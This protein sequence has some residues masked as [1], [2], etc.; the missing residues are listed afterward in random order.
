MENLHRKITNKEFQE[1]TTE[2]AKLFRSKFGRKAHVHVVDVALLL[3]VTNF[4][5]SL[6][7]NASR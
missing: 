2:H 6:L 5:Q 4:V 1:Q 3:I 7:L